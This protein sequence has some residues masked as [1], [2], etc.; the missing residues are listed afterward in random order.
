MNNQFEDFK[1]GGGNIVDITDA[2]TQE[3]IKKSLIMIG[4]QMTPDQLE[5]LVANDQSVSDLLKKVQ[6]LNSID[7][8]STTIKELQKQVEEMRQKLNSKV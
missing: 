8:Q 5:R 1:W 4:R 7:E 6:M 3:K 2:T